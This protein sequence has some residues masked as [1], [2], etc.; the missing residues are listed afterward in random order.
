VKP[1][2]RHLSNNTSSEDITVT[3]QEL[4]YK[5]ISLKQMTAK[6]PSP[7]G[8]VSLISIPLFLITLGRNQKSLDIFKIS[9]LC[10]I[11]VKVEAYKSKVA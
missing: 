9:N 3:L 7:E 2:I 11:N 10:N 1:V 8:A 6:H 4:G 5:V